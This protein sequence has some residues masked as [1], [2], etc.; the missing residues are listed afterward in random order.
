MLLL[1]N[2]EIVK[3]SFSSTALIEWLHILCYIVQWRDIVGGFQEALMEPRLLTVS[4][5]VMSYSKL[6][7]LDRQEVCMT[8]PVDMALPLKIK[9]LLFPSPPFLKR[10]IG[11]A[12]VGCS[13]LLYNWW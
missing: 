10:K 4:L 11:G 3:F 7:C 9:L 2:P 8:H 1:K 13:N 5:L 6:S 12:W